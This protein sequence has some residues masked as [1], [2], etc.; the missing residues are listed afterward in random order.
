MMNVLRVAVAALSL[1]GAQANASAVLVATGRNI[2]ASGALGMDHETITWSDP[3]L[4]PNQEIT[5]FTVSASWSYFLYQRD[6][7]TH[8][9][10]MRSWARGTTSSGPLFYHQSSTVDLHGGSSFSF[11]LSPSTHSFSY[12]VETGFY[13]TSSEYAKINQPTVTAI[14]EIMPPS[15]PEPASWAMML[16]GFGLAAIAMRCRKR[17]NAPQPVALRTLE[18]VASRSIGRYLF[19]PQPADGFLAQ[20]R[21]RPL[22]H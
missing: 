21:Q 10:M 6:S 11:D 12:T 15:I 20:S 5:G 19:P 2:S 16:S 14:I 9:L 3:T 1:I 18:T 22:L 13:N 17:N 8:S 7:L 4:L